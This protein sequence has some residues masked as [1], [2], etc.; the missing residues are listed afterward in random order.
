MLEKKRVLMRSTIE[1]YNH[2]ALSFCEKT[3]LPDLSEAYEYFFLTLPYGSHILDAGCGGGRD[4][5]TFESTGYEVTAFDASSEMIQMASRILKKQPFLMQFHE[6]PWTEHFDAIWAC[7]SLHHISYSELSQI[8]GKLS[9]SLK[10]GGLF[11]ASFNYGT[12]VEKWGRRIFYTHNENSIRSYFEPYFDL[13]EV[14]VTEGP[15]NQ[16]LNVLCHKK[17]SSLE[18]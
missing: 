12:G 15:S 1:Y 4:A 13:H 9:G 11:Y 5:Q 7:R 17:N 8:L 16:W 10:E 14:W 18:S 6:I 3:V 2:H